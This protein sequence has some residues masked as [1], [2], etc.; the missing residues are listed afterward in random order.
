MVMKL[1]ATYFP[2]LSLCLLLLPAGTVPATA[3]T[4]TLEGI[5]IAETGTGFPGAN[6]SLESTDLGAA[7]DSSGYFFIRN[8]PPGTYSVVASAVGYRPG[9]VEVEVV[10]GQAAQVTLLI[11]ETVLEYD[12]MVVTA[13]RREQRASRAPTSLSLITPREIESRNLLDLSEVLRHVPGV[14]LAGNTVNVRGSSG[15]AYNVGSRVLLLVDGNP[16]LGP[17]D[18]GLP[19]NILPTSQI[20]RV[21]VLKG[22]GSALYGGGALSGVINVITKKYPARPESTLRAHAGIYP[23]V[24]YEAWRTSRSDGD[25]FRPFGGLTLTRAHR[26]SDR[27]GYWINASYRGDT[28]Y[29]DSSTFNNVYA[30]GKFG[31][32]LL[33]GLSLDVLGGVVQRRRELFLFWQNARAALIPAESDFLSGGQSETIVRRSSLLPVLTHVISPK[34]FYTIRGRIFGVRIL[35]LDSEGNLRPRNKWTVAN[36]FGAEIQSVWTPATDVFVTAGVTGDW[37]NGRSE[38]YSGSTGALRRIQPEGAGFLQVEHTFRERFTAVGGLRYD[39]YAI[40]RDETITKLSPK[41]NASYVLLPQLTL[42]ASYGQGFRVPSVAERYVDNRDFFPVV[43]NIGLRPEQSTGY[44]LGF[45]GYFDGIAGI[46]AEI[47]VSG[48]WNTFED[49]VEPKF[50]P[51]ENAFQF[52]NL[53]RAR[54]R[55]AEAELQLG[56]LDERIGVSVAYLFLQPHDLTGDR[57]RPLAYRS[58]HLVQI[59]SSFRPLSFVDLGV[60]FRLAGKPERLDSD[61]SRFVPDAD[62]MVTQ[63]VLDL[64]VGITASGTE[65]AFLAKNA[66]DYY[67]VERPAILAP[68]RHFILQLRRNF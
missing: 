34:L 60:D 61:F 35:P 2:P 46:R 59:A 55:G 8:V 43:S 38:F 37:N 22:P 33:P 31:L 24:R 17:D 51:E 15:F 45:K 6:V 50:K 23:P 39:V 7:S 21:E 1:F 49:L 3:Q 58:K 52:V 36:R 63:R 64:R 29:L 48:F 14:Q 9:T 25:A 66:L 4:G 28:G 41:L 12:A 65:I 16:M 42:R 40:D 56:T 5:V 19:F 18:G 68:P 11:Q 27:L 10:A 30:H 13:S 57:V 20:S 62:L 47:D 67:Y 26:V 53:T 44:E 32:R 54:I